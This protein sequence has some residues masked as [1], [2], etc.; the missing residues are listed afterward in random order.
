MLWLLIY[1]FSVAII[2]LG[3]PA[4]FLVLRYRRNAPDYRRDGALERKLFTPPAGSPLCY[5]T[6][7]G[8]PSGVSY[9]HLTDFHPG[10]HVTSDG[11]TW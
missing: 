8:F 3:V 7:P 5:A 10:K 9:C 4:L 2:L 6:P 11:Y 1:V